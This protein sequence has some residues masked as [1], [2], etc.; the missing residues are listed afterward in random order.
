MFRNF[1][2]SPLPPWLFKLPSCHRAN[3]EKKKRKK[4]TSWHF[5]FHP[6]PVPYFYTVAVILLLL[7][8]STCPSPI[9]NSSVWGNVQDLRRSLRTSASFPQLSVPAS[10]CWEGSSLRPRTCLRPVHLSGITVRVTPHRSLS[11]LSNK[12]KA[13]HKVNASCERI[14]SHI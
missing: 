1:S 7:R 8:N 13:D 9:E 3:G 11:Q 5:L 10:V 2:P 4:N 14:T 6:C 12:I